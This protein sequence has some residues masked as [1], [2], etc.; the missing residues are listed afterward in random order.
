MS[1]E[2][3]PFTMKLVYIYNGT[4]NESNNYH[5]I[6]SITNFHQIIFSDTFLIELLVTISFLSEERL[7]QYLW[8]IFGYYSHSDFGN[9]D[10]E[11][12][13]TRNLVYLYVTAFLLQTM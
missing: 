11:F 8:L 5:F 1:M 12:F 10:N 4:V 2:S 9:C 3:A 7:I 13:I 6:K